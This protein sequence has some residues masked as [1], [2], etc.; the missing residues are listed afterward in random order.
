[1]LTSR[2]TVDVFT[3]RDNMVAMTFLGP[4]FFFNCGLAS[5]ILFKQ[6]GVETD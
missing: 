6:K 2:C 1:M 5:T 3:E 4:F